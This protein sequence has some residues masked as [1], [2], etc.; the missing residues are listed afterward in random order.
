MALDEEW[1]F[2]VVR[3]GVMWPG[4]EP[5]P[6]QVDESRMAYHDMP[7]LIPYGCQVSQVE[8]VLHAFYDI[9]MHF[10][11]FHTVPESLGICVGGVLQDKHE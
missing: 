5:T 1:G 2:N 3:L 7:A 10:T 11:S 8:C 4:V 9:L 6:G